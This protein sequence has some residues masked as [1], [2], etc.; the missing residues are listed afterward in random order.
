MSDESDHS[1]PQTALPMHDARALLG[2]E[3]RAG[4]MLD[5]VLY[6]LRLTRSGK[7]ILTK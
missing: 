5:G 7:L 3:M 6:I 1:M 4:I 2:P